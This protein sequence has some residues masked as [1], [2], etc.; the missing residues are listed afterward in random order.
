[1]S[2]IA[3]DAQHI[4]ACTDA[5]AISEAEKQFARLPETRPGLVTLEDDAG[6]VVWTLQRPVP[7]H[8]SVET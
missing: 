5:D 8:V 1:M 4:D 7:S 3:L 2:S 6:R